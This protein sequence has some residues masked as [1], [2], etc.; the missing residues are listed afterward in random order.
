MGK[1]KKP[2]INKKT[3]TSYKLVYR[4]QDDPLSKEAGAPQMVLAPL[5][6][7]SR[8]SDLSDDSDELDDQFELQKE[9]GIYFS[10]EYDY[11]QHLKS[12]STARE[13]T[14]LKQEHTL[15]LGLPA[16][17]FPS[18]SLLNPVPP[19]DPFSEPEQGPID[20]E[21]EAALNGEFDFSDPE[22]Q[23]EDDFVFQANQIPEGERFCGEYGHPPDQWSELIGDYNPWCKQGNGTNRF[24]DEDKESKFTE[25]SMTSSAVA[26]S[27][28]MRLLDA[29][30]ERLIEEYEGVPSVAGDQDVVAVD[31]V[32]SRRDQL[33][34]HVINEFKQTRFEDTDYSVN[35][36]RDGG[37]CGDVDTSSDSDIDSTLDAIYFQPREAEQWDCESILSTLSTLYNHPKLISLPP[38]SRKQRC[39]EIEETVSDDVSVI[40]R[41]RVHERNKGETGEERRERK[42]AVKQER[43]EARGRKKETKEIYKVERSS[44]INRTSHI[45]IVPVV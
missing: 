7:A 20:R 6:A 45:S 42:Q 43:R 4:G 16:D 36:T 19:F 32:T 18:K 25:C 3:A 23:L 12:S 38:I 28:G 40:S 15:P 26:R 21:I 11:L 30:F 35:D 5:T 34:E 2:W 14:L 9:F 39:E 24:R 37:V 41:G 33:L 31:D 44:A 10:D 22:A 17:V 1:K 8:E 27:E 29:Q 13:T